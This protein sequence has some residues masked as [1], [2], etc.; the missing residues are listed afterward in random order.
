MMVHG[1]NDNASM[2]LSIVTINFNNAEGLRKTLASVAVQ[3]Y[4][5]I[6][7]VIVDAASTDGSVDIIKDYAEKADYPILWSSK[8]DK[9]VY[10]GMNIGIMR[11]TGDYVW[12]LNSGDCAA[13]PD[14]VE[15][16]MALLDDGKYDILIGNKVQVYP[17]EKKKVKSRESRVESQ[18]PQP[19]EVS[20]LTFYSGTVPQDAAFV[21]R[22]L[23]EKYGYFDDK[24]KIVSD[25]KLYLN[26]IA[27]GDVKPMYV[28]IDLVLFDMTGISNTD[29]EKRNAEKR[30]CLEEVLPVSVLKDYDAY[31]FPI[32]QYQRMKKYHLWGLVY[33]LERILFKLEKWHIIG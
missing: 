16:M 1:L 10:N 6:E 21:R 31:A 3:T 7:H 29:M 8:K 19:M 23:F 12:I 15:R 14:V 27:L 20:M 26:M 11:A 33:F 24:L 32:H 30:A 18:E 2:K 25:W 22:E 5:D 17:R 9:G 28:N 13:A 4:R